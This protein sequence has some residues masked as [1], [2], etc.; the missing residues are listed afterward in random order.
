MHPARVT[1][2]ST[3]SG[4]SLLIVR[5]YVP[6]ALRLWPATSDAQSLPAS[7]GGRRTGEGVLGAYL[8][9]PGVGLTL[10]LVGVTDEGQGLPLALNL[11]NDSEVAGTSSARAVQHLEAAL[12]MPSQATLVVPRRGYSPVDRLCRRS[13]ASRGRGS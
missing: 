10:H 5:R 4:P 1:A 7:L 8:A 6:G 2:L 11:A 13:L 9:S 3:A 12:S